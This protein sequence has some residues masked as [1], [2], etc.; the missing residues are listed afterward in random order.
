MVSARNFL[1]RGLLAGLFAGIVAFGVAYVVGEPSINA[2]IAIEEAGSAAPAEEAGHTHADETTEHSHS[3]G[4]E[5]VVPRSLQSTLG[6]LTATAVAGVT[7]GGLAGVLSALALGRFGGLG[8]RATT[9]AVAGIGFV[10]LY[11]MPFVAYPPNPPAVGQSDTIALR[12]GLYFTMLAISVIAAVTA[13]VVGRKLART[14]SAWS[15]GLAAV[16]GY[17]VVTLVAIALLPTYNEVPAGFP[18][19]V[20]YEFRAASLVTQFALWG[21]L[22]VTLAELVHR[23]TR[24]N[25]G[26]AEAKVSYADAS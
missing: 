9:L 20:L 26:L 3:D 8:A 1:I 19:T 7:L 5:T 2:A 4:G 13:V 10:T 25:T 17:L 22:G 15:A 6:L 23:L 16:G 21:V 14:W 18:A 12:S 24:R 11:L